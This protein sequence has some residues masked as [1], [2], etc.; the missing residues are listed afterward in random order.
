M[1]LHLSS[2]A[3]SGFRPLISRAL[4]ALIACVLLLGAGCTSAYANAGSGS[5]GVS[6]TV[7]RRIF[8][9]TPAGTVSTL[10]D[11]S[12]CPPPSISVDPVDAR[13]GTRIVRITY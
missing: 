9:Q 13:T 4:I 6:A 5:M 1:R 3:N 2:F 10:C 12:A 11:I 7:V 8:A